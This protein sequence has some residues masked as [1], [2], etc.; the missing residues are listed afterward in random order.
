MILHDDIGALLEER[1]ASNGAFDSRDTNG[2][3]RLLVSSDR[4]DDSKCFLGG[5][6]DRLG[7]IESIAMDR[8]LP[9]GHFRTANP[10]SL[11][12]RESP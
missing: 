4:S 10:K 5:C 3:A 7:P 2:L 1:K 6:V 9:T 11:D 12:S 8:K